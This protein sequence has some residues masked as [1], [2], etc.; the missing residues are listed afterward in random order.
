[1]LPIARA[2]E[3]YGDTPT[4][5]LGNQ[6]LDAYPNQGA[7]VDVIRRIGPEKISRHMATDAPVRRT[8]KAMRGM[9]YLASLLVLAM[10]ISL[11]FLSESTEVNAPWTIRPALTA[12][13][14]GMMSVESRGLPVSMPTTR[15]EW[16]NSATP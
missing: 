14:L 6:V 4:V 16:S 2:L 5:S 11:Y 7:M 10:G 15:P 8:T 3:R 9:L 12:A 13:F 1:M